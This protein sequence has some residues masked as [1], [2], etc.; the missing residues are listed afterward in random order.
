[1]RKEELR[2][3]RYRRRDEKRGGR[4]EC[5]KVQW[6]QLKEIEKRIEP[7]CGWTEMGS[8]DLKKKFPFYL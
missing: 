2:E 5:S 3:G 4:R 6:V 7:V 1:M 8:V